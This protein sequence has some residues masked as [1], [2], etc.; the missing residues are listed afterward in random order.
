MLEL[1]FELTQV[2]YRYSVLNCD[3]YEARS[4]SLTWVVTVLLLTAFPVLSYL[5]TTTK[6]ICLKITLPLRA[7]MGM[8]THSR[9]NAHQAHKEKQTLHFSCPVFTSQHWLRDVFLPKD[10]WSVNG[11]G[12]SSGIKMSHQK[13]CGSLC[14]LPCRIKLDYV[15][16]A[17]DVGTLS[18]GEFCPLSIHMLKPN[19]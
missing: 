10:L 19:T 9:L 8:K 4:A 12:F 15:L 13:G 17:F 16:M 3:F 6:E 14:R 18:W 2:G 5:H 7:F 1:D 11:I